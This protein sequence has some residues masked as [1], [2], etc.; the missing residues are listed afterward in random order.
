MNRRSFLMQLGAGAA[1]VPLSAVPVLAE[2]YAD[3]VVRQLRAQGYRNI[4]TSRTL[5]GRARILATR[6]GMRR[7]IVLDPRSG[8]VLRDLL[9]RMGNGK[10]GT[11]EIRDDHSAPPGPSNDDGQADTDDDG[12]DDDGKDD[13]S[14]SGSGDDD[15]GDDDGKDDDSGNGSGDDGGDDDG[16]GGDDGGDGG[17]D[18]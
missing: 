3:Q 18:D 16:G 5:L 14:G 1:M 2:S 17:D 8:E 15:G 13:D 7:E 9:V 10:S 4:E 6:K 11:L 12:K